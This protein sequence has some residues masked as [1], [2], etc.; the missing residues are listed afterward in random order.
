MAINLVTLRKVYEAGGHL[1]RYCLPKDLLFRFNAYKENREF[2]DAIPEIINSDGICTFGMVLLSHKEYDDRWLL[3]N[4]MISK[5]K[6]EK[7][8]DWD[9]GS[10]L[11]IDDYYAKAFDELCGHAFVAANNRSFDFTDSKVDFEGLYNEVVSLARKEMEF[12]LEQ[13]AERGLRLEPMLADPL[14]A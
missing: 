9:R 13:S 4:L 7:G 10:M 2:V 12:A 11:W 1:N 8:C 3:Q 6:Y 5:L 14:A